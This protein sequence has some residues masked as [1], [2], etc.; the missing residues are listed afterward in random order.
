MKLLPED[1]KQKLPALYATDGV[2]PEEKVVH[3]KLFT[4]TSNWTWYVVEGEYRVSHDD[5][6]F[7]GLV[8][9]L[10]REW[11]Y[12]SLKE[13]ESVPPRWGCQGVERDLY[14][15]PGPLAEVLPSWD[16]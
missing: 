6:V 14:F 11:G 13:L 16:S 12:F 10:E 2:K 7:F 4:P 9:G 3:M 5:F 1:I 8:D 15:T